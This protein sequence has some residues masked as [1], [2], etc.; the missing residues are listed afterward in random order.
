MEMASVEIKLFWS[1]PFGNLTPVC[2]TDVLS[3][4]GIDLLGCLLM[5]DG[6]LTEEHTFNWINEGLK[7]VDAV[8]S[9][10]SKSQDWDREAWGASISSNSVEV[11]SLLEESCSATLNISSFKAALK[12][13]QNFIMSEKRPKEVKYVVVQ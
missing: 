4:D 5:D 9:G 1:E 11:Y 10:S 3:E 12:E 8:I 6:G 2:E 13:W 7:R